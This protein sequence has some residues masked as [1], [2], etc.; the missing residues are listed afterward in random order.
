MSCCRVSSS[1]RSD[2]ARPE[3]ITTRSP[4]T[5]VLQAEGRCAGAGAG[6]HP[7]HDPINVDALGPI[8][9]LPG[10]DAALLVTIPT[11]PP[12]G[13]RARGAAL[14]AGAAAAFLV[15]VASRLIRSHSWSGSVGSRPARGSRW[16]KCRVAFP[17]CWQVPA[18]WHRLRRCLSRRAGQHAPT[19]NRMSAAP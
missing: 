13:W 11:L 15:S 9:L 14:M 2:G 10:A 6:S 5:M 18:R 17:C 7:R 12:P 8:G 3:T 1:R 16:S 19:A 4:P